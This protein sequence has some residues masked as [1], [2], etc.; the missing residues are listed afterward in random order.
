DRSPGLE[1]IRL[2][3]K[4][5]DKCADRAFDDTL[6]LTAAGLGFEAEQLAQLDIGAHQADELLGGEP[7]VGQ[8]QCAGRR[9]TAQETLDL[10]T[11][12][13]GSGAPKHLT[14]HRETG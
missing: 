2:A 3:L 8:R 12:A 1:L 7:R 13:L 4:G 11:F 10:D 14:E 6:D 9:R 5:A